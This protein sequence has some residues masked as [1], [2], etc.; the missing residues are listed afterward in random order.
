MFN[1]Y[2]IDVF[3][4]YRESKDYKINQFE[5]GWNVIS[6]STISK[7]LKKFGAKEIFFHEFKISVDLGK[8]LGDP[9]RSWTEKLA[10]G[11]RQIVNG[12]CL[13]QPQYILE[14]RY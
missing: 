10:S 3:I 11:E 8:K 6:Q 1:P 5:P 9:V 7:L 2:E 12:I 14:A 4:K 13:K